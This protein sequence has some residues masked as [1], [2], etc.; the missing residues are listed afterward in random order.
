MSKL[1]ILKAQR[2]AVRNAVFAIGKLRE[3]GIDME[4]DCEA[5]D[6]A[7]S[8]NK[9]AFYELGEKIKKIEAS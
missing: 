1:E 2:E 9:S 8:A 3:L 7:R 6:K 5:M 4:Y